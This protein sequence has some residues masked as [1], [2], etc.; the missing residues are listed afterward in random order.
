MARLCPSKPLPWP[1]TLA[2]VDPKY[3]RFWPMSACAPLW[4]PAPGT[5]LRDY[6]YSGFVYRYVNNASPR[7]AASL[8]G[9]ENIVR[10]GIPGIHTDLSGNTDFLQADNVVPRLTAYPCTLFTRTQ[11][12]LNGTG[13]NTAISVG[14]RYGVD[15]STKFLSI[16]VD[17]IGGGSYRFTAIRNDG[18]A[19]QAIT[20][21]TVLSNTVVYN[22]AAVYYSNTLFKLF[23]NGVEEANGTNNI[24]FPTGM[25]AFGI[26]CHTAVQFQ[27]YSGDH[28]VSYM[29]PWALSPGELAM[30][31]DDPYGPIRQQPR[32]FSDAQAVVEA[33]ILRRPILMGRSY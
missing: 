10:D 30:L 33:A 11:N 7:A 3:R 27:D 2:G 21:T 23:V 20:G 29:F 17:D 15:G 16:K 25:T 1:I 5:V 24:A 32:R 28:F 19:E 9:N 22:V 8:E 18:S 4:H 12:D 6:G 31:E 26:G 13:D 14:T